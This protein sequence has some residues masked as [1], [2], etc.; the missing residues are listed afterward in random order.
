LI[1]RSFQNIQ[2]PITQ[3]PCQHAPVV[4]VPP[5]AGAPDRAGLPAFAAIA[6][7][8]CST[9]P[10]DAHRLEIARAEVRPA[11]RRRPLSNPHSLRRRPAARFNAL[12]SAI[13][14]TPCAA[15]GPCRA[16]D[17]GKNVI[18]CTQ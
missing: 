12:L 3:D 6:P 14:G 9:V 10:L 16:G 17:S 4:S 15:E 8:I 13:P 11:L 7:W 5:H 1:S 18:H 2:Y